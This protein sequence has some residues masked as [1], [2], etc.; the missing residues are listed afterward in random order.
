MSPVSATYWGIPGYA[1]FW[2]LFAIAA[3]LFAQ[4]LYFLFRLMRL[5]KQE[6]RFDRIG[7]RIKTMLVE[8]VPQWCNLKS[9]SRQDL[10]GVGHAILVWG[11][12]LILLGYII[13]IGFAGG[14]G[15]SDFLMG[16]TFEK[17]YSSITDIAAVLVL[18][19]IGW[20]AIRRYIMKP[21]R[22]EASAEAAIILVLIFALMVLHFCIEGFGYAA[23]N[24]SASWPPIGAAF[25]S[26]LSNTTISESALIAIYRSVW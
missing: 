5:G 15:L 24:I 2:V 9:V 8:V 16:N 3:G 1:I 12:L 7:Q 23:Y 10:A 20:A 11:F 17:I 21:E 13:F 4:R 26:F 22:L 25:A 19:A 6:N 18:I 14:F